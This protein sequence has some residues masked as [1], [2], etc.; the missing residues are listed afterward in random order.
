MLN[1]LS[2]RLAVVLLV[3]LT[4]LAGGC[5]RNDD[6]KQGSVRLLNAT[7]DVGSLSMFSDDDRVITDTAP[8]SLSG[9]VSLKAEESLDLKFKRSGNDSSVLTTATALG[10]DTPHT[11]VVWGREGSTRMTLIYDDE[12]A[13]P[14]GVVRVRVFNAATDAGSVDVYVG[15]EGSD[16]DSASAA[17]TG[18][19]VGSISGFTE[20]SAG[21]L[22]VRLTTAGNRDEWRLDIPALPTQGGQV[23]TLVLQP[24][25]GGVLVHALVL[26]QQGTVSAQKNTQSR[27]RLVSSVAGNGVVAARVGDTVLSSGA[28]SPNIGSYVLVPARARTLLAQVGGNTVA[29]ESMNFTPGQDYTVLVYGN[30]TA[31]AAYRISDDN[32]AAAGGRVKMRLVHGVDGYDALTLV[33][34]S[35]SVANDLALGTAS[36]FSTIGSNVGNALLEVTSPLSATPLYTTQRQNTATTGVTL[37]S[38]GVYTLFMLSGN[39]APRGFLRRDR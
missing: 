5:S 20:L 10:K 24:T 2:R 37:E 25:P 29:S 31:A 19:L 22:R 4:A 39:A 32:R 16:L 17:S 23:I 8:D 30:A 1:R 28:I 3:G 11:V 26:V 38:T 33:V 15:S 14:A 7:V 12:D 18:V 21:N 13:P 9:Y 6:D 36:S 34:D 27:V 35:V